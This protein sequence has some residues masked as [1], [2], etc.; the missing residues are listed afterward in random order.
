MSRPVG[1]EDPS[2]VLGPELGRDWGVERG[3]THPS[4]Q[5]V[6]QDSETGWGPRVE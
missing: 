1:T 4:L 2:V 6:S 5:S 3:D